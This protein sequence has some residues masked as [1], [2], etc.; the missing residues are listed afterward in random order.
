MN[1][2][3][4]I[5]AGTSSQASRAIDAPDDQRAT[6]RSQRRQPAQAPGERPQVVE[7]AALS[8]RA[9]LALRFVGERGLVHQFGVEARKSSSA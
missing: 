4:S 2:R 3:N 5:G 6:E 9:E 7:Q 1:T 8:G